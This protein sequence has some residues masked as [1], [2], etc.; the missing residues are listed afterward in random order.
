MIIP[1]SLFPQPLE[2]TILLSA[3]MNFFFFKGNKMFQLYFSFYKVTPLPGKWYSFAHYFPAKGTTYIC[4]CLCFGF[5][6]Q[7]MRAVLTS[8]LANGP[9]ST[10]CWC[11]ESGIPSIQ[12][13]QHEE[14]GEQWSPCRAA[15]GTNW[16]HCRRGPS[17]SVECVQGLVVQLTQ[18]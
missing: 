2:T 8:S 6:L 14:T 18:I 13:A 12:Q 15:L 17:R 7:E 4:L 16:N 3:P 11:T 1:H 5:V 10:S 9:C